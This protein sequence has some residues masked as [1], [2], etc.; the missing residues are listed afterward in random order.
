MVYAVDASGRGQTVGGMAT[1]QSEPDYEG[2]QPAETHLWDY[3]HVLLRRRRL[4][5]AVFVVIVAAAATR[6]F[7]T[8]PVYQATAQLLIE[9]QEPNVLNFQG[10]MDQ[11]AGGFGI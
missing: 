6:S 7:L 1:Q 2:A 11:K 4:I 3:V 8:K 5:A 10:V 9:K